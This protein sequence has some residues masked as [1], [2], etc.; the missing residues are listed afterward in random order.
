M[1]SFFISLIV[2]TLFLFGIITGEKRGEKRRKE[3]ASPPCAAQLFLLFACEFI[4]VFT[5][6]DFFLR[7]QRIRN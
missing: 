4:F 6:N 1:V 5:L 7:L 2:S 3:N